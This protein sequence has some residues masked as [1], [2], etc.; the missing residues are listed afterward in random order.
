[1]QKALK[2]LGI[3]ALLVVSLL[4]AGP[5]LAQSSKRVTVRDGDVWTIT[6]NDLG[7]FA[8]M[9]ISW[10]KRADF[11]ILV[12]AEVDGEVFATCAGQSYQDGFERCAFGQGAM[13]Y[14]LTIYSYSGASRSKGA[15]WI[16]FTDETRKFSRSGAPGALAYRGNVNSPGDDT[17]LRQIAEHVAGQKRLKGKA[18]R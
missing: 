10:T 8:E 12:E 13:L 2:R 9:L 7:G 4:A 1:M 18:A 16:S 3:V 14:Y 17:V 15:I 6:D 11:D 5:A